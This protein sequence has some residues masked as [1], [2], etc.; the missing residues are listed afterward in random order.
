MILKAN[1]LLVFIFPKKEVNVMARLKVIRNMFD[2]QCGIPRR[3]GDIF[4]VENPK[5]VKELID[6]KVVVELKENNDK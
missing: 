3:E 6:K 4:V 5:R 2:V 1:V